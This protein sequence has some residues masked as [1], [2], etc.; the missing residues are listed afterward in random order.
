MNQYEKIINFINI[1]IVEYYDICQYIGQWHL[2]QFFWNRSNS[3][4]W[5]KQIYRLYH[6]PYICKFRWKDI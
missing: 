2:L 3:G 1:I 6:Y 5:H 4:V